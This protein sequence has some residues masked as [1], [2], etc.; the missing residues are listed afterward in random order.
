MNNEGDQW[1]MGTPRD[2]VVSWADRSVGYTVKGKIAK[3]SDY[4]QKRDDDGDL[5]YWDEEKTQPKMQLVVHLHTGEI[6]PDH[7]DHEGTWRLFVGSKGLKDAIRDAVKTS[8]AKALEVGG[9]LTVEYRGKG[10]KAAT[11]KKTHSA[12][13]LFAA[14]YVPPL[15]RSGEALGTHAEANILA[16]TG[17]GN[18]PRF[19]DRQP[20][21][22]AAYDEPPF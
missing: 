6:K 10:Q 9:I 11:A 19:T 3:P 13:N 8:H 4:V 16:G 21:R 22:S 7:D 15:D 20:A 5:E 14:E 12:P 18:R 17:G 2:P 1:L